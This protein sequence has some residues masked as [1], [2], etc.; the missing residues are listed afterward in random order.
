MMAAGDLQRAWTYSIVSGETI[1][2]EKVDVR[3][4]HLTT[5]L[6]D[7]TW[8]LVNA[9]VVNGSFKLDS[10]HPSNAEL[11]K[12]VGG[13][14]N[15]PPGV[16]IPELLQAWGKLYN[17]QLPENSRGRLKAIQLDLYRW[18]SGHYGDYG[19]LVKTW[20]KEL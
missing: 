19:T 7:R 2:G 15:L 5:P 16:R 1:S 12:Q 17:A 13:I 4:A 20:R 11:L 3:P 9:T 14:E 10:L 6:Y 18:D 8:G